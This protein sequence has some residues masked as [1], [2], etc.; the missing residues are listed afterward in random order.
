EMPAAALPAAL[1]SGRVDAATL[2][3]AQAFKASE[4]GEFVAVTQTAGDLY[5]RTGVRM[6]SAVLAGYGD[7]LD[8]APDLDKEVLRGLAA[9]IRHA[10]EHGDEV[11]PVVGKDTN[12]DPAFFRAWLTRS[13]DFPV[14]PAKADIPAVDIL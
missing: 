10:A 12:P 11:S 7:Q 6:V 13:W 2:I 9:S 14:T 1:A 8:A 3:H 4:T 5:Q